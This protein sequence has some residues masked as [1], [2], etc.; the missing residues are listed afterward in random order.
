MLPRP[1]KSTPGRLQ[2]PLMRAPRSIKRAKKGSAEWRKPL[3]KRATRCHFLVP[4]MSKTH[5]FYSFLWPNFE[6][7][8]FFGSECPWNA[9]RMPPE[10]PRKDTECP[11]LRRPPYASSPTSSF[12]LCA[13]TAL[14]TSSRAEPSSVH[15]MP[16]PMKTS[17]CLFF[18]HLVTSHLSIRRRP[19]PKKSN[20]NAQKPPVLTW[21]L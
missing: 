15:P 13:W 5:T 12:P 11:H 4:H 17:S 2:E 1:P 21:K 18:H 20:T 6:R 8:P 19:E 14:A 16:P 3:N 10:C 7:M 9:P